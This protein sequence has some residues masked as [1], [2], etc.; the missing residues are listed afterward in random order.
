[1][2][3]LISQRD[4]LFDLI[5]RSEYFAPSQFELTEKKQKS[6]EYTTE[7][8]LKNSDYFF[9]FFLKAHQGLFFANFSP[10]EKSIIQATGTLNWD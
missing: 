10:G 5:E 6:N 3:L 7:L 1:M 9:Y 4:Y 2:K 8:R